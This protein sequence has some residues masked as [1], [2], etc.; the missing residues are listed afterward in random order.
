MR[1]AT[2]LLAPLALLSALPAAAQSLPPALGDFLREANPQERSTLKDVAKRLYPEQRQAIDDLIEDIEDEEKARVQKSSI[3]EGWTGEGSLGGNYSSGNTDEWNFSAALNIRR[4]G[5]LWEHRIEANIDFS[6]ADHERTEER[7]AAAY[8][9]R[10]DFAKSPFFAF[11]ALSYDRDRFQ[12]I[13]TRF[14]ESAGLGYELIDSNDED[15]KDDIDWDIYAGPA[16]RQTDFID[17]SSVNQLGVFA[18]TDLKWEIT[19]RLTFR[20]Y[21]GAVLA[22]ENKSFKATTSLTNN[23][24]GRLSA[25]F[26]L[27]VETET[28]PP[29][30]AEETDIYSR[31]SVVYDF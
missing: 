30:D 26:E 1:I 31:V 6:D 25:R 29:P 28:D 14:T 7:I 2:G 9:M 24:Y 27:T 17:G 8:R 20:Q 11:G 4:K 15:D 3:V 21:A 5:P 22:K 16:F 19:D 10:R 23:L 12:G 18:A 13:G